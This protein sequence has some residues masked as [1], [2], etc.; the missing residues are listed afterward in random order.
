[1]YLSYTPWWLRLL[2][3]NLTWSLPSHRK[4][5]YLTFDDGPIPEVTPW[6]L[7]ML[8]LY[9]AKAT[10]FCVG[11]NI[12][13]HPS[14][15]SDVLS[16]GHS[17]GNH[18]Y[19][20]LNGWQTSTEE[21]IANIER[22]QALVPSK[23]F[24]PP[25]GK[26]TL[27]QR[28]WLLKGYRVVMWDVLSGDFDLGITSEQCWANVLRGIKQGGSVIVFHDSIKAQAHLRYVLPRTLAYLQEQGYV[29]EAIGGSDV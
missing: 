9:G 18:T 28:L 2:F 21:Y 3:P 7:D 1:M 19:N 4:V 8:A 5:V 15:L 20:H 22:C 14:I 13:R 10:F 25:Y 6:V 24:R 11:E 16:R 23:L 26:T 17:V 27:K 29:F 12:K